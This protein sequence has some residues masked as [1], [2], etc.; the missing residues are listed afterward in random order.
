MYGEEGL[1]SAIEVLLPGTTVG[2]INATQ[3]AID[4]KI[5]HQSVDFI[6][7]SLYVPCPLRH[8]G[9]MGMDFAQQAAEVTTTVTGS[10]PM[11][12]WSMI[13]LRVVIVSFLSI[14][15]NYFPLFSTVT[16]LSGAFGATSIGM[17]TRGR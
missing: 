5:R 3:S 17:F 15:V 6:C 4:T 10:Q 16:G 14:S 9:D 12:S 8:R 2:M 11:M 13:A 7:P 1:A